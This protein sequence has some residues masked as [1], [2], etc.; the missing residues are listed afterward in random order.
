MEPLNPHKVLAKK[1]PLKLEFW[2]RVEN[3]ANS[4]ICTDQAGLEAWIGAGRPHDLN[5]NQWRAAYD[6]ILESEITNYFK[7]GVYERYVAHGEQW[8]KCDYDQ[9]GICPVCGGIDLG[10]HDPSILIEKRI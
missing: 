8:V 1:I 2:K 5:N 10:D 3:Y 6:T 9:D 4:A 7:D